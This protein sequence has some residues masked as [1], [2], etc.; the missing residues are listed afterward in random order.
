MQTLLDLYSHPEL[1]IA[2]GG[3][4]A[5]LVIVFSETG[6]LVGFFLPGDSLLVTAGLLSATQPDLLDIRLL[7]LLLIPAAI[8]GDA[9]GYWIGHKTGPRI[10][11]RP[12]S[13][14]FKKEHLLATKA[15]YEK[16]GGKTIIIAR[17]MP[18]ARTFAPVVAGVA[19]M[20]Y[21]KFATYN[22]I[23]GVAWILSMTLTGYLLGNIPNA[24]KYVHLIIF[25]VVFLSISPGLYAFAK[26]KLAARRSKAPT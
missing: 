24:S 4:T 11:D 25:G 15:F 7:N 16:H 21:R 20:G 12:N 3:Y 23:G 5:L 26:A 14:F 17:F 9:T 6:L 22:I 1:L 8:L 2:W 10:Y 13:R 19:Q 18:F